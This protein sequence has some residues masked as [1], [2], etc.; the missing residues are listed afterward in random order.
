MYNYFLNTKS[1]FARHTKHI[2]SPST[3]A[4][5]YVRTAAPQALTQSFIDQY[6]EKNIF[7]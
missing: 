6:K 3:Q 7:K 2:S 4:H 5:E 1:K